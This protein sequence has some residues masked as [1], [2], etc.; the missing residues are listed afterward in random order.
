METKKKSFKGIMKKIIKW[1]LLSIYIIFVVSLLIGGLF[2]GI[3]TIIPDSAS[4]PCYLGYYAHCSFTPFS[5]LILFTMA[6]IGSILLIKLIKYLKK[7]M[8]SNKI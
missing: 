3:W 6:I 2:A 7:G 5:T 1:I 8:K 4:K